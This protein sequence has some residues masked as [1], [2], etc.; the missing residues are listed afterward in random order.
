MAWQAWPLSTSNRPDFPSVPHERYYFL[1]MPWE[2]MERS[3]EGKQQEAL[4]PWMNSLLPHP[5]LDTAPSP[6]HSSGQC[7]GTWDVP[8]TLQYVSC[9]PLFQRAWRGESA[10]K[11]CLAVASYPHPDTKGAALN[12]AQVSGN[13][14]ICKVAGE[15]SGK[16]CSPPPP[17]PPHCTPPPHSSNAGFAPPLLQGTKGQG[18]W[19][20]KQTGPES[21]LVSGVSKARVLGGT[22]RTLPW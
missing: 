7:V 13:S 15:N 8:G 10:T 16:I 9:R 12:A 18:L 1:H 6:I 20:R 2:R 21:P 3:E 19:D 5:P 14:S 4:E 22:E 17:P 11:N